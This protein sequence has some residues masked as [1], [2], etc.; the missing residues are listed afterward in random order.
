MTNTVIPFWSR[1]GDVLL[2]PLRGEALITLIALTGARL[3]GF[4]PVL[5]WIIDLLITV[6][7]LKYGFEVLRASADGRT[8]A[9]LIDREVPDNAGWAQ[10]GLQF[11][12]IGAGL[13]AALQLPWQPALLLICALAFFYPAAL[14]LL[15]MT[16]SLFNALNPAR[17][18][19]VMTRLGGAY[20]G[21]A[22]LVLLILAS[23]VLFQ[24]LLASR[25]PA[26]LGSLSADFVRAW[27]L[28]ASYHLMGYVIYQYQ[29]ALDH[30][31]APAPVPLS[32]PRADPDQRQLDSA[33]ALVSQGKI[34]EAIGQLR[35]HISERGATDA[36]HQLYRR[37][38]TQTQD[39]TALLEHGR[40][41]LNV[42]LANERDADLL[43]LL[44]DC[45]AIDPG[46]APA[47]A[48]LVL[49][50]A[51]KAVKAGQTEMALRLTLDFAERHPKHKHIPHNG[52]L[53]ARLLRREPARRAQ[54]NG[55]L[56]QLQ[57]D[58]PN[59]SLKGEM[60]ALIAGSARVD[61]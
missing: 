35:E 36:V 37:L 41:Y 40:Q 1:L 22:I 13:A 15:A 50:L 20:L 19:E 29:D 8:E 17:W 7:L 54:A 45:Q 34:G 32:G 48:E 12:F 21:L 60:D 46:F 47:S 9:P 43:R 61:E 57:R 10:I 51:E 24:A 33:Q 5:G 42:L 38:L 28:I 56:R 58:Y 26:L 27:A 30:T 39:R 44:A 14:M 3:L 11:A 25:L 18:W 16:E 55:L 6:A 4:L 53:A 59:H 52:L 49:P 23:A 31:P 2:Y